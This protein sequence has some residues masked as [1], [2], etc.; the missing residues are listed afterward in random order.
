MKLNVFFKILQ[1]MGLVSNAKKGVLKK[2]GQ[3]GQI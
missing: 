3:M 2:I 1:K